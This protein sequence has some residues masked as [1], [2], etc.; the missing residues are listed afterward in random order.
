MNPLPVGN[1]HRLANPGT[2]DLVIIEAQAGDYLGENDIVRLD[3]VY[4]RT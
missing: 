2:E 1:K 3:D 4:G